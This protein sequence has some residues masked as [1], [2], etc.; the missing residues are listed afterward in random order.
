MTAILKNLSA[1]D[2]K[3]I[4]VCLNSASIYE[5]PKFFIDHIKPNF[6]IIDSTAVDLNLNLLNNYYV[7]NG[8]PGDQLYAGQAGYDGFTHQYMNDADLWETNIR[9]NPDDMLQRLTDRIDK[10]FANWFYEI[11][12]ENINSTDIPVETYHDFNWWFSFNVMWSAIYLR[13]LHFTGE[14]DANHLQT[15]LNSFTGWFDTMEYQQ[16]AM[17]NNKRG[18]K[19]SSYAGLYKPASKRYIYEFDKDKYYYAFK[20]KVASGGRTKK[21]ANWFCILN[22]FSRLNL[23]DDL[24]QILELFPAH[25][26][27]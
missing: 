6:H 19:Y 8:E 1:A 24:E 25:I 22:D 18:Q 10:P 14:T 11:M 26:N 17:N 23:D 21:F 27:V 15:Y 4:H 20:R 9:T 3:N 7:I 12:M 5:N 2:F 16:W 13:S